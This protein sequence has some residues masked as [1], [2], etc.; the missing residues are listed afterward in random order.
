MS[1]SRSANPRGLLWLGLFVLILAAWAAL[2]AMTLDMPPKGL[3][4]D[5][6]TSLCGGPM[7]ASYRVLFAMWALMASAMMLPTFI[8]AL[9]TFLSLGHT[10]ATHS[11]DAVMLVG[12]YALVWLVFAA[13]AAAAQQQLASLGLVTPEGRSMSLWLTA[14][15]LLAAGLYQFSVLKAA[16]LSKCRMPLTFFME[17]WAPGPVR[18]FRMGSELGLACLGCCWA[19]MALAFVGGTM[20]LIWMG[21][22]TLF[23]ALE[24]LPD[25][26]RPLTRPMGAVLI[27]AAVAATLAALKL[28]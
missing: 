12:G 27:L 14:A 4:A 22:A 21:A 28:F 10:G 19:L 16:C 26:G 2:F 15:L 11:S 24:K 6:W 3:A 8:P 18:A 25:I 7:T 1:L 17:R 23:M 20:N 5:V 9:R 13:I